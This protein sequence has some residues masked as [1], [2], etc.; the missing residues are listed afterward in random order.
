MKSPPILSGY[1]ETDSPVISGDRSRREHASRKWR[2]GLIPLLLLLLG[3][4][5]TPLAAQEQQFGDFTYSSDGSAITI[6]RFTGA[7]GDVT[8]PDTIEGLPVRAI[9]AY[10]FTYYSTLPTHVTIPGSVSSVGSMAFA[11]SPS[12]VSVTIPDSVTSIEGG[13]FSG[14]AGLT[15]ITIPD[16]VSSMGWSAFGDCTGL[17][18]ATIPRNVTSFAGYVFAGCASLSGIEVA[19]DNPVYRDVDGIVFDQAMTT[20]VAYPPGRT[21]T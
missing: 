10:A 1:R 4:W 20:L 21:G 14:C 16:S 15:S 2:P 12:L 18:G 13:A 9:Q 5:I 19:A 3:G 8:I 17:T 7:G 6:V 11:D